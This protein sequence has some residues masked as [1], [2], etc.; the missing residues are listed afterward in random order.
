MV[1]LVGF[2]FDGDADLTFGFFF[3]AELTT[4]AASLRAAADSS[5]LADSTPTGTSPTAILVSMVLVS[6][7]LSASPAVSP[8]FAFFLDIRIRLGF[9][10]F[11][12]SESVKK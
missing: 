7:P 12:W 3:L 4:G 11:T 6:A 9:G 1:V 5:A 10:G 8:F 2:F